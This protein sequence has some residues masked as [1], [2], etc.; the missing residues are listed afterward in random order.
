[1]YNLAIYISKLVIKAPDWCLLS[2]SGALIKSE[3]TFLKSITIV[4][5]CSKFF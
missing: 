4:V 5:S 3:Y 2:I 1:M